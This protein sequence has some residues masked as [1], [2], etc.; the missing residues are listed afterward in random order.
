MPKMLLKRKPAV[1]VSQRSQKPSRPEFSKPVSEKDMSECAYALEVFIK[2]CGKLAEA[3]RYLDVS[4]QHIHEWRKRGAMGKHSAN[5]LAQIKQC[6]DKGF[7][8]DY[9]RPDISAAEWELLEK[10]QP[11]IADSKQKIEHMNSY[12]IDLL[13][14]RSAEKQLALDPP[15]SSAVKKNLRRKKINLK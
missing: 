14:T 9:M 6:K 4:K 8:R 3:T 15:T 13:D 5:L 1:S 12:S 11:L 10:Q 7:T 2:A